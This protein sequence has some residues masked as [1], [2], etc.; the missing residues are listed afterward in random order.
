MK[1]NKQL[2]KICMD[3]YTE[4]YKKAQP[5]ADFKKLIK[6]GETQKPNWFS[7][8][9]LDDKELRAIID[10]HIKKHKLNTKDKKAVDFEVWLGCSPTCFKEKEHNG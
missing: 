9:Y 5:S 3:I 8:Y 10:K 6:S 4:L 7:K 2:L 1:T